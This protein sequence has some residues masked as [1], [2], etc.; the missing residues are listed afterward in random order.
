LTQDCGAINR[1]PESHEVHCFQ[2]II[3]V[4]EPCTLY[5]VRPALSEKDIDIEGDIHYR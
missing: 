4:P 3:P 2:C 1:R 5:P